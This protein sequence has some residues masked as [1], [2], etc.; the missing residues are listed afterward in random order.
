M[1]DN[2]T[3]THM[4]KITFLPIRI[5]IPSRRTLTRLPAT[6]PLA[7]SYLLLQLL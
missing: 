4:T 2:T 5:M 7:V 6:I 1:R 3:T